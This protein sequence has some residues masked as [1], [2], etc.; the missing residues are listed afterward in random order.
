MIF[1][2]NR[3]TLDTSQY[4]LTLSGNSVSV[5]PQVF[6][7]LVY[8]IEN[9]DRVVTRSELLDKIWEGKVV[10][11]AALAV[12]LKEARKVVGDSGTRQEVIKTIHGRGYQFIAEV[13]ESITDE[14]SEKTKEFASRKPLLNSKIVLASVGVAVVGIVL[15][16]IKPWE[17]HA[18]PASLDR[19][20][21]P[22]PDKPSIAVL[23]FDN[24]SGDH[25]QEYLSDGIS[26]GIIRELSRFPQLFVIARSSSFTYKGRP[27]KVQKV[28]E[29]LGVRYVVEGSFHSTS[30]QIRVS[31][32][33]VDAV[34]GNYLWSNRFDRK[35]QEFFGIQ[36]EIVQT[37]VSTLAGRVELA[38]RGRVL[39]KPVERLQAFE[40][41]QLGWAQWYEYTPEANGQAREFYKK[42]LEIDPDYAEAYVGLAFVSLNNLWHN[43]TD[44][45]SRDESL[46]LA[47][48]MAQKAAQVDRFYYRSHLALANVYKSQGKFVQA[49]SEYEQALA[50]NPN[51]TKVLASYAEILVKLGRAEEAVAQ[52]RQA[53]RLSPY[54][55]E[56]YL[57]NLAWAQ[58]FAGDYEGALMSLR[59]MRNPPNAVKRTQAVI[60]VRINQKEDALSIGAEFLKNSP[61]YSL[62]RFVKNLHL[63]DKSYQD[64]LVEDL[65]KA[66]LS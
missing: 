9:R 44:E 48:K 64:K 60:L 3:I 41:V 28:S 58:Y 52:I 12:S 26:E 11:D 1:Q 42:A 32:Q 22:L 18:T 53:I 37:I 59:K 62:E 66:G 31:A 63:K 55:P 30:D 34:T 43:W 29:E 4:C 38:E 19:M 20:A 36:D 10:T 27:A 2:F 23:A 8:L 50:L 65:H 46:E 16:W 5:E 54:H 21:F 17:M 49:I 33:L 51:A 39:D 15:L 13:T 6:D 40:Y 61:D 35:R 25:N 56:W 7:L 45:H 57:W 14:T 24:L 47:Y